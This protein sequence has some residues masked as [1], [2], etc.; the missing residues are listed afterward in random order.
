MNFSN[1]RMETDA[2]GIAVI[3][4][5]RPE[6]LNAL[7]AAVMADLRQAFE[8]AAGDAGVR[9]LILTGAGEKA[10]VAGADI[11]ELAA[12]DAVGAERLSAWGQSTFRMLETMGKP[13]VAAINGFCL[14]GGME[15]A[16]ACTARI[17]SENAKLGQPEVKL[18]IVPGYGA[19]QRLPR[20]VGRAHA[21]ELLLTGEV[22]DAATA[23]RMGLVNHVAPLAELPA[24]SH[25][26]LS[27]ILANGPLAVAMTMQAVDTGY[28]A[29]MEAG[30][31]FE[32]LS[33]GLTAATD[34]RRE[35]TQAFLE[36][37]APKF[38]GK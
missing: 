32:A 27:K 15:L 33:F 16:L 28:D 31:R 36:K 6:K 17:A 12:I 34:D 18:G 26:W 7:N 30:F 14:G 10:F 21:L 38:T 11:K 29:G 8:C 5:H 9:G 37:R 22:I 35:G 23:H 13:S 3:T 25:A 19:T 2:A 24:F 1:I 4:I 20:L